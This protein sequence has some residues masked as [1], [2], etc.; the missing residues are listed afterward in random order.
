MGRSQHPIKTQVSAIQGAS[1]DNITLQWRMLAAEKAG[2]QETRG[3]SFP[4]LETTH[5]EENDAQGWGICK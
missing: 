4:M 1:D 3:L 5:E 2:S